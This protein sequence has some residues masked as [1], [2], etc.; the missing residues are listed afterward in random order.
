M[1]A[2]RGVFPAIITPMTPVGGLNETAFREVMEFDIQAGAHGFWI[3][4]GTGESVLLDDE[5]NMRLAEIAAEHARGRAV[6]I[7]HVGAPTTARAARMAEHAA[8]VG[9]DAVCCVPPF[10]YRPSDEAIVEHY[11]VIAAAADLPFFVY[12]LP[13]CTGTEVTPELMRKIQERV[14]Q[15]AGLKHSAPTFSHVRDFAK[16]NLACIIGNS[17]LMLPALTLG[18]AGCIDG[19]LAVAPELW[20]AIW[21]AYRAGDLPRA[22][23]AQDRATEVVNLVRRFGLHAATKALLGARVG[24]DCGDPRPPG[25]PLT[26][27]QQQQLLAR[28]A[29]LGLCNAT[30][31]A[32]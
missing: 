16:M 27:D 32:H 13:Q 14:P 19:P 7:M 30:I 29:A 5:E 2:F 28:A 26:A 17:A 18:A 4:G 11:R 24:I 9:V 1:V 3:A 22:E 20:V 6:T 8:R 31:G 15:V 21:E 25:L 23:H 12:N 10:F